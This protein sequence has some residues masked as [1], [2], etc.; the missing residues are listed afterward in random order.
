[1]KFTGAT[2]AVAV[3]TSLLS[4]WKKSTRCSHKMNINKEGVK[5]WIATCEIPSDILDII[6]FCHK[7]LTAWESVQVKPRR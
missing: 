5:N 2:T 3:I 4:T 7:K 1:M 6:S